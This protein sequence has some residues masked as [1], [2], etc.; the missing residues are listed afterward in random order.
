MIYTFTRVHFLKIRYISA[1]V[2]VVMIVLVVVIDHTL[3]TYNELVKGA[4]KTIWR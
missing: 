3:Y 4:L 1:I 2:V